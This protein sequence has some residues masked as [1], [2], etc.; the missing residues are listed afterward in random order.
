MKAILAAYLKGLRYVR[1]DGEPLSIRQWVHDDTRSDWLFISSLGDRHETLRPLITAW[2]DIAVNALLSLSPDPD[3]RVW[4]I[5]DE[6]TSLH[7]IPYLTAAAA[8]A[9][10]FGGCLV[11][12]LQSYAQLAQVYGA[13]GAKELSS[14]CNTRVLFRQPDPEM[15]RWAAK[16]LGERTVQ[17]PSEGISYGANTIRDGISL[18]SR[19]NTK[20]VV[21]ASQMMR[22][23]NLHSYVRLPGDWPVTQL[24]W[25]YVNR[26]A[27]QAAFSQRPLNESSELDT[28]LRTHDS[29]SAVGP[30]A[31]Y[32]SDASRTEELMAEPGVFDC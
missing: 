20:L 17:E 14:L 9:R 22:L 29:P 26:P 30:E 24:H 18:Q 19:E 23:P 7:K 28:L 5:L 3:R 2:L 27:Y 12:G 6:L 31:P 25:R 1:D 32:E 4:F 16:N 21:T 11:L 8:E 10:K 15:A 13:E